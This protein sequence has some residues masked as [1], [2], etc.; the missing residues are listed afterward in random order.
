MKYENSLQLMVLK[1]LNYLDDADEE[2]DLQL[3]NNTDWEIVKS[4]FRK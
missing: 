1:S 4:R 3:I 2:P